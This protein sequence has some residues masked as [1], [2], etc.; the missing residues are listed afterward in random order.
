VE[1][2]P[3]RRAIAAGLPALMTAH[4]RFPSV[5]PDGLPATLSARVLTGL[6][7]EDLQFEGVV[8]TDCLEMQAIQGTVGT[9]AG[10]MAAIRAGADMCLISHTPALYDGAFAAIAD[11]W[12]AGAL[13]PARVAEAL[14]R[15]ERLKARIRPPGPLPSPDPALEAR[16]FRAAVRVSGP[17]RLRPLRT[18]A[19]VISFGG[20]RPSQ[21]EERGV[22]ASPFVTRLMELGLVARHVAYPADP[23][24]EAVA[25]VRAALTP[26]NS[27]LIDG[28]SL[29][30]VVVWDRAGHHPGQVACLQ[31]WD[32]ARP[33][34]VV[35]LS[36][37]YDLDAAPREAVRL[38]A[39]D[40]TPPA[41]RALAD[42]LAG[43]R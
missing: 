42:V 38:T 40:P 39:S 12:D 10:A 22:G 7:R 24:P 8:I 32:P 2:F 1:L 27:A 9:V 3:F 6:V 37:P 30:L 35:A 23:P 19:L 14:A 26:S 28:D 25:T 13:P 4:V 15:I 33:L 36:N 20:A 43:V 17:E 5:E 16:A 11:A 21:A 31:A 34:Y 41:Q 18:P 29:P